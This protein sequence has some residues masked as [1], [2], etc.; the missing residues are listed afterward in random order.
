MKKQLLRCAKKRVEERSTYCLF[1]ELRPD[2][3]SELSCLFFWF[4]VFFVVRVHAC[5]IRRHVEN[6]KKSFSDILGQIYTQKRNSKEMAENAYSE[7]LL[8]HSEQGRDSRRDA[9]LLLL[10]SSVCIALAVTSALAFDI[11]SVD[12]NRYEEIP[13]STPSGNASQ[14]DNNATTTTP[15]PPTTSSAGITTERKIVTAHFALDVLRT[16]VTVPSDGQRT[17]RFF[18]E[19][20]QIGCPLVS[21]M[22]LAISASSIAAVASSLAIAILSVVTLVNRKS[23]NNRTEIRCQYFF[24][25]VLLVTS[26]AVAS[27]IVILVAADGALCSQGYNG[28]A[29]SAKGFQFGVSFW[30]LVTAL[31]VV[32]VISMFTS[33]RSC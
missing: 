14:R 33:F 22:A 13:A 19:F 10:T 12:V 23:T 32:A 15:S 1:I 29:A 27:C 5:S 28:P 24:H 20:E 6:L 30:L 9:K 8:L 17:C 11:F 26:I 25:V 4:N 2:N 7:Y 31:P 16:C 3:F 18:W 21:D